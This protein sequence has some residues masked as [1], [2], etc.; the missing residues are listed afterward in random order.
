LTNCNG[1]VLA[2]DF[3][4]GNEEVRELCGFCAL[5]ENFENLKGLKDEDLGRETK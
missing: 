4:K 2:R 3:V 5:V 1:F